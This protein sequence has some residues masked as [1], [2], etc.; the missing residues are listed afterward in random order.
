MEHERLA[1][2]I[3]HHLAAL[4][5]NLVAAVELGEPARRLRLVRELASLRTRVTRE[6]QMLIARFDLPAAPAA[7][8]AATRARLAAGGLTPRNRIVAYLRE[9]QELARSLEGY[10]KFFGLPPVSRFFHQL[11]FDLYRCERGASA[12]KDQDFEPPAGRARRQPP[13]SDRAQAVRTALKA[14]PLYFILDES[15]CCERDPFE[16]GRQALAAGVRVIQLRFKALPAHELVALARELRPACDARHCLLIVNDR[17]D[18][19]LLA[20][21]DGVH[22]GA[23]D[24]RPADARVLGPELII[25]ATAR[26]PGAGAAAQADG[27]DYVGAGSVFGSLTKPGLPVIGPEGLAEIAAALEIPVV[28]IGGITA[29]NCAQVLGAGAGGFA[30]VLP[31]ATGE[32][33]ADVAASLLAAAGKAATQP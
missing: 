7:A 28:G 15:L 21:A 22:L 29:D 24:L 17:V 33:I 10:F 9:C 14:C 25:G 12:L 27:A 4:T 6:E 31:F 16:I 26:N 1:T 23:D 18:V 20:G 2:L 30:S 13:G 5:A 3:S 19:A 11:R 32:A 8:T